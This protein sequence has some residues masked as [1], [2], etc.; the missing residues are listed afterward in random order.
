MHQVLHRVQGTQRHW[1]IRGKRALSGV[2]QHAHLRNQLT[3]LT[4]L[5][6]VFS[7]TLLPS[8]ANLQTTPT[9]ELDHYIPLF[10][11]SLTGVGASDNMA[12]SLEDGVLINPVLND[13]QELPEEKKVQ[14]YIV[15]EG[16][17]LSA[18]ANA[19][20][21]EADTIVFNNSVKNNQISAGQVL[22]LPPLDGL[23]YTV[24]EDT[25]LAEIAQN[26]RA[27]LAAMA[28]VNDLTQRAQLKK[29]ERVV[30]PGMDQ[31]VAV[32]ERLKEEEL[33]EKSRL[34][35]EVRAQ[36][37]KKNVAAQPVVASVQTKA[38]RKFLW[39]SK[40]PVITQG[41]HSGHAG[42]DIA[43]TSG[44]RTTAIVAAASGTVEIAQGGWNGGYGNTIL[45][46]HGN[47]LR[48]R[49]AHMRELYVQPGQQVQAGQTIGWM[50]RT[51]NVRG[52][53][54]LHLHFE[55]LIGN[56][57]VNPASYL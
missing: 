31:I 27:D 5:S 28:E 51:G 26:K 37:A 21:I 50:G 49:Y 16:D 48:T 4:T 39:P 44:D 46:N 55:V 42:Y 25:T 34:A 41:Y 20:G 33:A 7:S 32:K 15:Q 22:N 45:I 24:E 38:G 23:L 3:F 1:I 8:F 9:G 30:I 47:G 40:A 53:T 54:G 35:A 57:R 29:G 17:T 19:Y 12:F 18:L 2:F 13:S 11:E 6:F 14:Q 43:Y 36:Q 56:R 10:D 52:P